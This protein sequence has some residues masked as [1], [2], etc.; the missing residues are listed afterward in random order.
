MICGWLLDCFF[1]PGFGR[2]GSVNLEEKFKLYLG[3][4]NAFSFNS[5][6]SALMAILDSLDIKEGDEVLLQAFTCNSAVNPILERGAKPVFVDIDDTLNLDPVDLQRKITS[7]SKAVMIQHTF[8]WPAQIEEI[9]NITKKQNLYLIEDAAHS[10][11]AKYKGKFCG[12]F[13]DAAFFSFGRDKII[14]SVF[15]GMAV[16]TNYAIAQKIVRFREKLDYPS[17]C[18]IS[19][20]LVHP[21]L[22]KMQSGANFSLSVLF[23]GKMLL[24]IFHK[25]WIL[26]KA[27]YKEE[28]RG[29]VSSHF[30]KL[31]PTA[32]AL[33]AENQ[34]KKA[35]KVQRT[36]QRVSSVLSE[37]V[38]KRFL[39]AFSQNYR[40]NKS[41]FYALS[42][43][44]SRKY[45]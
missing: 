23:L 9:Q 15:G 5:G 38:N 43:F 29:E 14:S 16:T 35:G 8:G 28:K 17:A 42:D 39:F 1:S 30:P 40:K 37:R 2:R 10:L 24:G 18:W 27:V 21:V 33:L 6:R 26:S 7:K 4:E 45:R 19:Q 31:M 13:G 11:G 32:L 36:S 22:M 12:T 25:L 44:N 34:F 3:T 41:G 20:Q